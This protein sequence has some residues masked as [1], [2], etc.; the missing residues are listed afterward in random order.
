MGA[1]R[2]R[3]YGEGPQEKAEANQENSRGKFERRKGRQATRQ[4]NTDHTSNSPTC[5]S[6]FHQK[7]RGQSESRTG[8]GAI[9]G[10]GR[11]DWRRWPPNAGRAYVG[12]GLRRLLLLRLGLYRSGS[13]S[14]CWRHRHQAAATLGQRGRRRSTTRPP[15]LHQAAADAPPRGRNA[16][17]AR[18]PTLHQAA[19]NREQI[20]GEGAA[21][22]AQTTEQQSIKEP[23]RLAR[24]LHR[25][26]STNHAPPL[27]ERI[28]ARAY[29]LL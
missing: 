8:P 4:R 29:V 19:D 17:A 21:D 18:P 11:R 9:I 16:G 24:R 22:A 2:R 25:E 1:T 12:P 10:Q 13:R 23:H 15:A 3:G 26:A 6:T 5:G 20:E 7:K 28:H 14:T 27:T